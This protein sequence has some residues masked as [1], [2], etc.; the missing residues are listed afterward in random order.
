M[1]SAYQPSILSKNILLPVINAP[2]DGWLLF[3]IPK[4]VFIL[5]NPPPLYV[6]DVFVIA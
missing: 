6:T 5:S 2:P 3:G 1:S 4:N